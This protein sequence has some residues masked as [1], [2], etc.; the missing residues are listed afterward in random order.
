MAR[1]RAGRAVSAAAAAGPAENKAMVFVSGFIASLI[2]SGAGFYA[3]GYAAWAA[4]LVVVGF[5]VVEALAV[6][7]MYQ[8]KAVYAAGAGLGLLGGFFTRDVVKW[9]FDGLACAGILMG[10]AV[11]LA[12]SPKPYDA[13]ALM[14]FLAANT[15]Y[16]LMLAVNTVLMSLFISMLL[17]WWMYPDLVYALSVA[18]L[19]PFYTMWIYMFTWGLLYLTLSGSVYVFWLSQLATFYLGVLG[20]IEVALFLFTGTAVIPRLFVEAVSGVTSTISSYFGLYASAA[21][22]DVFSRS[23]VMYFILYG[24]GAG[25]SGVVAQYYPYYASVFMAAYMVFALGIWS[26]FGVAPIATQILPTGK[27][28]WMPMS[29]AIRS[30]SLALAFTCVALIVGFCHASLSVGAAAVDFLNYYGSEIRRFIGDVVRW[31]LAPV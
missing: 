1:R 29:R 30:G 23:A 3:A 21:D 10:R 9:L 20:F 8:N 14:M 27:L 13:A 2:V 11:A 25:V 28:S 17:A 7:P 24:F 31:I 19:Y 26:A 12:T 4:L 5:I 6:A 16:A 15:Q 22:L 18:V